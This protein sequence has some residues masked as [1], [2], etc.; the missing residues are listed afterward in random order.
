MNLTELNQALF[1]LV[2][3]ILFLLP[4]GAMWPNMG[5][6]FVA[7][8][9][10]FKILDTPI[11]I[12]ARSKKGYPFTDASG[13]PL[14]GVDSASAAEQFRGN[15]EA[16]DVHFAYPTRPNDYI[17]KGMSLKIDSG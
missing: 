7:M 9:V 4:L 11:K 15:I 3:A 14:S 13:E 6:A 2:F 17:Y 16:I 1:M 8:K 5:E 10:I 12:D